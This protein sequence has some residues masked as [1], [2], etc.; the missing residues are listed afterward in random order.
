MLVTHRNFNISPLYIWKFKSWIS[1][2]L[3][4]TISQDLISVFALEIPSLSSNQRHV[5]KIFGHC[6]DIFHLFL[7]FMLWLLMIS[8]LAFLLTS[9]WTRYL[10]S[11]VLVL[12][13]STI[14]LIQHYWTVTALKDMFYISQENSIL[15]LQCYILLKSYHYLLNS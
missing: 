10:S 1:Y 14:N 2:Q 13:L 7:M 12:L 4:L 8:K 3:C 9:Q 11:W 15:K 5:S 6:Q